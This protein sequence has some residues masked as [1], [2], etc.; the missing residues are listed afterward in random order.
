MYIV[1]TTYYSKHT[2]K[3]KNKIKNFF[4]KFFEVFFVKI[5]CIYGI[6]WSGDRDHDLIADH[7]FSEL[8]D[9]IGNWSP[10]PYWPRDR[11]LIA[12]RKKSYRSLLC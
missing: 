11:E 9:L 5:Q 8:P 1:H 7:F 12:D 4:F 2:K 3:I 6:K 10:I